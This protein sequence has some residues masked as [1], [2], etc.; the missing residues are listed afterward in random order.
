M[1]GWF[2]SEFFH[3][4]ICTKKIT[5]RQINKQKLGMSQQTSFRN[6]GRFLDLRVNLSQGRECFRTKNFWLFHGGF[7]RKKTEKNEIFEMSSVQNSWLVVFYRGLFIHIPHFYG[8]CNKPIEGS[9]HKPIRNFMECYTS[10]R[11]PQKK[12][13]QKKVVTGGHFLNG[14]SSTV[15]MPTVGILSDDLLRVEGFFHGIHGNWFVCLFAY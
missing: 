13:L 3:G 9:F 14:Y 5:L 6:D 10:Q 12:R 7:F 2:H 15:N 1:V 4:I 8:D 11:N